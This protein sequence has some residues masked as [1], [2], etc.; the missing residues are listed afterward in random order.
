[1]E[2]LRVQETQKKVNISSTYF[3]EDGQVKKDEAYELSRCLYGAH[4]ETMYNDE[5][6]V[7]VRVLS[8]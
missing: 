1:M 5:S 8:S 4:N 6:H 3:G 2:K 7:K